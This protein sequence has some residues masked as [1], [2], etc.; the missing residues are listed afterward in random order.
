[1]INAVKKPDRL[2]VQ[3]NR[4]TNGAIIG[5]SEMPNL[6]PSMLATLNNDRTT[7]GFKPSLTTVLTEQELPPAEFI[8]FGQQTLT[9]E[10][11]KKIFN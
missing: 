8:V 4:V 1:M 11:K 3:T 5:V 9:I 10:V 2:Y 7:G 6:P